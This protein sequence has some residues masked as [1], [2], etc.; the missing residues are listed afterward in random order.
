MIKQK[1]ENDKTMLI[2]IQG[3]EGIDFILTSEFFTY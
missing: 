1:H 2:N 3:L